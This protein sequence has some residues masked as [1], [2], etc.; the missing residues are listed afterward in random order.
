MTDWVAAAWCPVRSCD[1]LANVSQVRRKAEDQTVE[2]Q[3]IGA[4]ADALGVPAST[5]RTWEQRYGVGPSRSPG[6]HRRYAPADVEQLTAL[7]DLVGRGHSL[8]RGGRAPVVAL[9]ESELLLAT[10]RSMVRARDVAGV[11]AALVAFVRVLGGDVVPAQE[12]GP[13]ALPVDLSFGDGPP[14]LATAPEPSITRFRLEESIP[15]L[16]EDGRRIVALLRA[17]L[18]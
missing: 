10:T 17:A 4:V 5:I 6:G 2:G 16:H 9:G 7:R 1:K 12:A 14:Q 18:T 13:D 8:G 11:T 15:A 3:R